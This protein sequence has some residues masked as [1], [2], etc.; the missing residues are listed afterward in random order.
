MVNNTKI[1]K[2]CLQ[3]ILQELMQL[4]ILKRKIEISKSFEKLLQIKAMILR[5]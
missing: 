1:P 3:K 2:I 5:H 4:Q